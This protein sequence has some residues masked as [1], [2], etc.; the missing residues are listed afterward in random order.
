MHT[1]ERP[2]AALGTHHV[3]QHRMT[4]AATRR[5]T[6]NSFSYHAE[7]HGHRLIGPGLL[8]MRLSAD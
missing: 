5:V 6:V 1:S 2:A 7:L 8:E 4:F 3:S